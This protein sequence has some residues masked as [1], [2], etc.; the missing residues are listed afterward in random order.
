IAHGDIDNTVPFTQSVELSARLWDTPVPAPFVPVPGAGHTLGAMPF[1]DAFDFL[2]LV[3]RPTCDRAADVTAYIGHAQ[4][5]EVFADL[6]AP[7]GSFDVFD[8][9]AYVRILNARCP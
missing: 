4:S 7:S 2:D 1:D 9:L 5:G 8:L 3:L 6:A